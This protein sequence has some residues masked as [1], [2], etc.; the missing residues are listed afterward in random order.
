MELGEIIDRRIS[1]H[2]KVK[3]GLP[4]YGTIT[5]VR[6]RKNVDGMTVVDVFGTVDGTDAEIH[7]LVA[8]DNIML[9]PGDR[10]LLMPMRGKDEYAIIQRVTKDARQNYGGDKN[11]NEESWH[12]SRLTRIWRALFGGKRRVRYDMRNAVLT[13]HDA[14]GE[15]TVQVDGDWVTFMQ[16]G[17]LA[18]QV[19]LGSGRVSINGDL[20]VNGTVHANDYVTPSGAMPGLPLEPVDSEPPIESEPD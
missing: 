1:A 17:R 13:I 12:Y 4:E 9:Y 6:P 7:E 11:R 20:H 10:V 5:A 18:M 8:P 19:D 2:I 3:T 14:S 15:R 16:G